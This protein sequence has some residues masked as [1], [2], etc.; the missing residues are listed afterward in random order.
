MK[1]DNGTHLALGAAA[2][3]AAAAA[4]LAHKRDAGSTARA[5]HG[6]GY[7]GSF[8]RREGPPSEQEREVGRKKRTIVRMLEAADSA[9]V[10]I[11]QLA[12]QSGLSEAEVVSIVQPM[13][14]GGGYYF[15]EIAGKM[16][17][18]QASEAMR[19]L[20]SIVKKNV[21]Q[22]TPEVAVRLMGVLQ[23]VL[24]ETSSM[25]DFTLRSSR[26]IVVEDFKRAVEK[27]FLWKTFSMP[28]EGP[29]QRAELLSLMGRVYLEAL[30]DRRVLSMPRD[31]TFWLFGGIS[32]DG[33][34]QPHVSLD[35][36]LRG[37]SGRRYL[38]WMESVIR[39]GIVRG[40]DEGPTV[41]H[42]LKSK[43]QYIMDYAVTEAALLDGMSLE[44]AYAASEA[45]HNREKAKA[46]AV[47]IQN[48]KKAGMWF[49]C[50]DGIHPIQSPIAVQLKNGWTW[51]ELSTF[52]ELAYE[53]NTRS[54]PGPGDQIGREKVAYGLGC[55]RHCVGSAGNYL[56]GI[57]SGIYKIY[58]LRTPQNRP[59][60]TMTI[61]MSGGR[62]MEVSQVKG[63]MNRIAGTPFSGGQEKSVLRM[64]R[65]EGLEYESFDDYLKDEVAMVE[66]GL[67]SLGV[68]RRGYDYDAMVNAE[69]EREAR[70][71]KTLTGGMNRLRRR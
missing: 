52:D 44:D 10:S 68:P 60:Q 16:H 57:K 71:A 49:E 18:G 38:P 56:D 19:E 26:S 41:F 37:W 15:E 67:K 20:I 58:S 12:D 62:P 3:L 55:L 4:I 30:K 63:F 40:D 51:R 13:T 36:A 45:W 22:G 34:Q 8:A 35:A 23:S 24:P 7:S 27:D 28:K 43:W 61:G 2:A 39:T 9:P 64:L 33:E 1:R 32:R 25:E 17:A 47:Q 66:A 50:A 6:G 54:A 14:K 65:E 46:S 5:P 59:M 21:D 31:K 29:N 48:L 70:K 69:R 42:D 11:E 53:G